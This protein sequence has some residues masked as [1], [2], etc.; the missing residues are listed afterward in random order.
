MS[1]PDAIPATVAELL[2]DQF[3]QWE[4]RG[5]G[6]QLADA[7]V[8][9]EPPFRPF[10]GHVLPRHFFA[11]DGIQETSFSRFAGK[12]LNLLGKPPDAPPQRK[13]DAVEEP[14]PHY[15]EDRDDLIELQVQLPKTYSPSR[16]VMAQCLSSLC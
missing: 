15:I 12:V 4:R 8:E 11:D 10:E 2:T 3:Y 5:R 6:W 16:E 14:E 13:E 7:P 1:E 9:L